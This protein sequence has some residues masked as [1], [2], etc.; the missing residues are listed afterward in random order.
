[1]KIGHNPPHPKHHTTRPTTSGKVSKNPPKKHHTGPKI[2][3][4]PAPP[5]IPHTTHHP[6]KKC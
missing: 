1:M 4:N 5:K 3:H 2:G 6:H